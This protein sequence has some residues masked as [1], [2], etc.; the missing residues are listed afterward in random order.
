MEETIYEKILNFRVLPQHLTQSTY[1]L[2]LLSNVIL[3]SKL[4][5]GKLLNLPKTYK[6]DRKNY[7]LFKILINRKESQTIINILCNDL[8]I[9][10]NNGNFQYV[11]RIFNNFR[12]E[13]AFK[14]LNHKKETNKE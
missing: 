9:N 7:P 5:K 2:F 1:Q 11:I 12:N 6:W 13:C 14:T 8:E 3:N 4:K 10:K